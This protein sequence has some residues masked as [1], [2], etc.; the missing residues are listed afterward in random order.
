MNIPCSVIHNSQKVETVQMSIHT[1]E[2]YSAINSNEALTEA[3]TWMDLDDI[4]QSEGSQSQKATC[5]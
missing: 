4:L 5:G 1:M 3:T 2:Y